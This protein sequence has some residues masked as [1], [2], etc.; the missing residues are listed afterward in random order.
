MLRRLSRIWGT[1]KQPQQQGKAAAFV[2]GSLAAALAAGTAAPHL[3]S[4]MAYRTFAKSQD[5]LVDS[6]VGVQITWYSTGPLCLLESL[7]CRFQLPGRRLL[8]ASAVH[9]VQPQ[10]CARPA[11]DAT[12]ASLPSLTCSPA[13]PC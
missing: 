1:A 7:P 13:H 4:A 9:A 5:G 8:P 11:L 2:L 12:A 6:L 3:L 10:C